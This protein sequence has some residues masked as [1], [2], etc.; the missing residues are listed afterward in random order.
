MEL[1]AIGPYETIGRL[2]ALDF[3]ELH[4]PSVIDE[5]HIKLKDATRIVRERV[6]RR[7]SDARLW[8]S[9]DS[10][11]SS[12]AEQI[13]KGF[14]LITNG[15]GVKCQTFEKTYGRSDPDKQIIA[16]QAYHEWGRRCSNLGVN[17]NWILEILVEGRTCSNIDMRFN[18]RKGTAKLNLLSGLD[19]YVKQRR[20]NKS[21]EIN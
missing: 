12:A 11:Q 20:W 8:G 18:K 5:I 19:E 17:V 4:S 7:G 21:N 3:Q 13:S 6:R 1:R 10:L 14:N 15:V 16:M 2:D 9:L